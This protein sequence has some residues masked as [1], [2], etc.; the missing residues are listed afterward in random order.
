V[1]RQVGK[2]NYLV[3]MV[4]QRKR[5]RVFHINMK[6][7][8]STSYFTEETDAEE[9][10]EVL[11]WDGGEDGEPTIGEQLPSVQRQQP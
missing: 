6:E 7:P 5:K 2:V 1:V 8:T 3:D 4:G 10:S 11:T 9:E